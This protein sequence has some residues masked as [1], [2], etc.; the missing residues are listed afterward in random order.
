MRTHNIKIIG[1]PN[2][3]GTETIIAMDS[4]RRG[5]R[6]LGGE[7]SSHFMRI[8]GLTCMQVRGSDFVCNVAMGR[9]FVCVNVSVSV[10]V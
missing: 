6:T 9:V 5:V 2:A 10:S 1:R 4:K 3:A 7:P 8:L